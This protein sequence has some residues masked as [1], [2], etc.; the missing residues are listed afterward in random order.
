MFTP[1]LLVGLCCSSFWFY[2]A[3]LIVMFVFIMCPVPNI[4]CVS[5]FSFL[6]ASSVFSNVYIF[7]DVNHTTSTK[8]LS[9]SGM[10]VIHHFNNISIITRRSVIMLEATGYSVVD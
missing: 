2:V 10:A 7:N 9:V 8:R 6:I 1:G 4:A 3:C 5:G